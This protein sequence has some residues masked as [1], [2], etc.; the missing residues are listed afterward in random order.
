MIYYYTSIHY[1]LLPIF[2]DGC[3]NYLNFEVVKLKYHFEIYIQLS[4]GRKRT[5]IAIVE[6]VTGTANTTVVFCLHS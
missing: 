5:V 1:V 2:H 3:N 4:C 6:K